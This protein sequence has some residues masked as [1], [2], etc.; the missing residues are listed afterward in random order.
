ML[1]VTSR[2]LGHLERLLADAE[3]SEVMVNGGAVWV[4]RHGCLE[5]ADLTLG[6]ADLRLLVDRLASAGGVR[7][8]RA[9]PLADLRLPDGSRANVVLPPVALGGPHVTIRRFVLRRATLADFGPP[10]LAELLAAAV[11]ER[12]DIIVVGGTS[13]GK[14]TLLNALASAIPAVERVVTVEDTAE[15]RPRPPPRGRPRGPAGQRRRGGPGHRAPAGGQRRCACGPT[16][17]WSARC[18]AP[19]SWTWPRP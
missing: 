18:A 6:P 10:A 4:E 12:R 5:R 2:G 3:V 7:V 14:T 15:L 17:S 8:D 1:G 9:S 13:S 11:A 16:A 19:R